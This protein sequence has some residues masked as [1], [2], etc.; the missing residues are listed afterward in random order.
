MCIRDSS[1]TPARGKD[2]SLAEW[3]AWTNEPGTKKLMLLDSGAGMGNRMVSTSLTYE[4]IAEQLASD[5]R[6]DPEAKCKLAR[7]MFE[8]ELSNGL[9]IDN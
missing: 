9:C 1:G 6:F 4:D 5:E 7:R 2:G 3:S 8:P